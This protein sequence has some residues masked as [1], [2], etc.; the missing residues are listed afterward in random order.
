M[1]RWLLKFL[2]GD[3]LSEITGIVDKY[4]DRQI[5]RDELEAAI[6]KQLLEVH[7]TVVKNQAKII[8]TEL[9][10]P[11]YVARTWRA[12]A[13][14]SFVFVILFY[15]LILPIAVDWFG[16]PPVRVGDVLLLRVIDIALVAIAGYVGGEGLKFLAKRVL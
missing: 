12:W 5:S 10:S 3:V 8:Q 1:M 11:D 6:R 4:F 2:T 15:V 13:G 9:R 14:L 7:G 16:L